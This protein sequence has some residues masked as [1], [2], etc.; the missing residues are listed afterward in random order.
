[1]LSLLWTAIAGLMIGAVAK[2]L[3][4]DKDPGGFILTMLLGLAGCF[5]AGYLGQL[6]GWYK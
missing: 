2:L 6:I 4:P 5:V 1:M 3:R